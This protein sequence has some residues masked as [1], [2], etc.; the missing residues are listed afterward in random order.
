[1]LVHPLT[2]EVLVYDLKRNKAHCLNRTAALVWERCDGES[3]T[4]DIARLLG[5][6]LGT[7]VDEQVVRL[8]IDQLSKALLLRGEANEPAAESRVSRREVI[9]RLGWSAAVA[10]PL[11]TSVLAPTNASAASCKP[12]GQ[13]CASHTECCPGLQCVGNPFKHC[14]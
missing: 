2:S 1:M 6:E 11:V 8:A 12:A 9:R 3:S 10:L 5:A 7:S 13:S 4:N 14:S